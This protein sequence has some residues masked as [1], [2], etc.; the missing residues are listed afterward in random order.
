[1]TS[2]GASHRGGAG[3]DGR[4]VRACGAPGSQLDVA[5]H[6]LNEHY[7]TATA[8]G[9]LGGKADEAAALRSYLPERTGHRVR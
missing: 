9:I 8:Y 3:G 4:S 5:Q 2:S 7:S 6:A 1:V